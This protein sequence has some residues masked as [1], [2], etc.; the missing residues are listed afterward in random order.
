MAKVKI[1]AAEAEE[2]HKHFM[3]TM[4]AELPARGLAK[5]NTRLRREG[6]FAKRL[7]KKWYGRFLEAGG[8]AGDWKAFAEW[9]L[10][11]L[12]KIIAMIMALF[13]ALVFAFLAQLVA[14]FA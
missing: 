6:P 14:N 2:A 13:P 1:T 3:A 4:K 9:L 7:S 10:E 8:R 5:A 12:P 11:N